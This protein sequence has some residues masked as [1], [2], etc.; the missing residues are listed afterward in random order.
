MDTSEIRMKVLHGCLLSHLLFL[1]TIDM[2]MKIIIATTINKFNKLYRAAWWYGFCWWHCPS[3]THKKSNARK[4]KYN[5]LHQ[6]SYQLGLTTDR[7]KTKWMRIIHINDN[8][9]YLDKAS[10]Q[11]VEW[12]IQF[13][14]N[15]DKVGEQTEIWK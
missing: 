1:L 12:Y 14:R 6:L 9:I 15:V 3:I 2:I 7:K 8:P 10:F 5:T 11:E 4:F 13:G